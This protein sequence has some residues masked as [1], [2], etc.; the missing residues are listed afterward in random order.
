M[1]VP[2]SKNVILLV[3][4]FLLCIERNIGLPIFSLTLIPWLIATYS[5]KTKAWLLGIFGVLLAVIYQLP[6]A[7]GVGILLFILMG[8]E[9]QLEFFQR[10]RTKLFLLV[11]I[12]NVVLIFFLKMHF[13]IIDYI[14]TFGAFSALFISSYLWIYYR[15]APKT[16]QIIQRLYKR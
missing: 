12:A 13:T 9:Y 5:P 10:Q 2:I 1:R 11:V 16:L 3:S 8:L 4:I 7:L 6:L 15:S 14:Y